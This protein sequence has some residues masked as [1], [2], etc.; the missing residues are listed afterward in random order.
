MPK[1]K[2]GRGGRGKASAGATSAADPSDPRVFFDINVGGRPAGRVVFAL[3]ARVVPKTAEN[4]RQLCTGEA[5][6]GKFGRRLHFKVG[7]D[8][9]APAPVTGSSAGWAV[10]RVVS[11]PSSPQ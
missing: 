10:R 8:Y 5:G 6:R 4:F 3:Y 11:P 1:G 9:V 7:Q 2:R